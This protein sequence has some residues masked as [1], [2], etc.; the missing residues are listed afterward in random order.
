VD[1]IDD[2]DFVVASLGWITDLLNEGANIVHR[3]VGGGIQFMDGKGSALVKGL[4]GG[5]F[6]ASLLMAV[7]EGAIDGFGQNAST[8]CLA[9]ASG[10]TK[11][12]G[13]GQLALGNGITQGGGDMV[14]T[15]QL[16]KSWGA[17]FAGGNLIILHLPKVK[18]GGRFR[19]YSSYICDPE[20][21]FGLN[22]VD[23]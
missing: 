21:N 7:S 19:K 23:L 6:S 13:L 3:I 14:L 2:I 22:P 9:D 11:Q 18:R 10:P 15:D 16:L 12:V 4:A 5:A 8:G 1:L 17:V 20:E